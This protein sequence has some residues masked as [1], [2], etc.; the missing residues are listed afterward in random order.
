MISWGTLLRVEC[1]N[2]DSDDERVVVPGFPSVAELGAGG[3]TVFCTNSLGDA[4]WSS[5]LGL[6]CLLGSQPVDIG[7]K[8]NKN[9]QDHVASS[10]IVQTVMREITLIS[11]HA[12]AF[13]FVRRDMG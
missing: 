5:I 1:I 11:F 13:P 9:I 10:H 2:V 4:I 8:K 7:V 3:V 6:V 12:I